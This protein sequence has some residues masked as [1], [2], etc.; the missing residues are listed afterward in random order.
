MATSVLF[1]LI[2]TTTSSIFAEEYDLSDHPVYNWE[3]NPDANF[4]NE[5]YSKSTVSNQYHLEAI[6]SYI[7]PNF[8]PTRIYYEKTIMTFDYCDLEQFSKYPKCK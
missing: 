2:I 7:D 4:S 8:D 1:S 6:F 3:Y 5:I